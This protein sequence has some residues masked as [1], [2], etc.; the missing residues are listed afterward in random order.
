MRPTSTSWLWKSKWAQM[1]WSG[2]RPG[3][4]PWRGMTLLSARHTRA[5]PS[6]RA[7]ELWLAAKP[8]GITLGLILSWHGWAGPRGRQCPQRGQWAQFQPG[9]TRISSRQLL[10]SQ[11]SVE[12]PVGRGDGD[13]IHGVDL[14]S[15]G[16]SG[17]P[18]L[19]PALTSLFTPEPH[20]LGQLCACS[21]HHL[22]KWEGWLTSQALLFSQVPPFVSLV[23]EGRSWPQVSA[24][25][26]TL[27]P[28]PS[29]ELTSSRSADHQHYPLLLHS[30]AL[31]TTPHSPASP[32]NNPGPR[33]FPP[34]QALST[35]VCVHLIFH[36][37]RPLLLSFIWT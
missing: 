22:K 31:G 28:P 37:S 10:G 11:G 25:T 20:F 23:S 29:S 30:A 27:S 16:C 18:T 26:P 33:P 35:Q 21:R 19:S 17:P 14:A 8:R 13:A 5:L 9:A 36:P 1:I 2:L 24:W 4:P 7:M 6:A 3:W 34:C 12:S 32:G 15:W